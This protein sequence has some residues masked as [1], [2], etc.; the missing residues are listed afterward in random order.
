MVLLV[1]RQWRWGV[2]LAP[3]TQNVCVKRILLKE[4][5]S[6]FVAFFSG[7]LCQESLYRSIGKL[8]LKQSL[9]LFVPSGF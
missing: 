1:T 3:F 4:Q 9:V 7:L 6:T 5:E 8:D 2:C